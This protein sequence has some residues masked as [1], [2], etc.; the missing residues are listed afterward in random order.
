M[1]LVETGL[2]CRKAA[3]QLGIPY[4]NA[5]V[6]SRVYRATGRVKQTPAHLK[7]LAGKIKKDPERFRC[8]MSEEHFQQVLEEC[9]LNRELLPENGSAG[10]RMPTNAATDVN[11]DERATERH[12][13]HKSETGK[14][15]MLTVITNP[16]G[17]QSR[18]ESQVNAPCN[19]QA[20]C[21][22]TD[23][24]R[25][26]PMNN[27]FVLYPNPGMQPA[28]V[29]AHAVFPFTASNAPANHFAGY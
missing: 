22:Q 4:N 21:T 23:P 26:S 8:T 14:M 11:F 13:F 10:N 12:E 15:Q 16:M 24:V 7:R 20:V 18:T 19:A 27:P 17:Q 28:A 5:K 6:I 3:F 2:S 9:A 1:R 29:Q 25:V